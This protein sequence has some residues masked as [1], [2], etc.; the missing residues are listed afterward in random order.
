MLTA[1]SVREALEFCQHYQSV[2]A[3]LISDIML[4]QFGRQEITA[5]MRQL[6]PEMRLLLISGYAVE[7]LVERGLVESLDLAAGAVFFLQK[8]F[9]SQTLVDTVRSII[10]R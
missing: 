1:S 5:Q 7:D 6:R 9:T 10:A 2:I 8:P 3:V 4:R